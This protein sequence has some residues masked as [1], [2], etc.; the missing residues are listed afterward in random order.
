M[1]DAAYIAPMPTRS[2][3][4]PSRPF[5]VAAASAI[6]SL[7]LAGCGEA[8]GPAP[9]PGLVGRIAFTRVNGAGRDIWV[10]NADGSAQ[11]QLTRGGGEDDPAF[12]PDGTQ[13]A[14]SHNADDILVM[15]ANGGSQRNVTAGT[16][17]G[18]LAPSWSR[19]GSRF[20][21]G[22]LNGPVETI[23][24]S[25]LDRRTVGNGASPDWAL[26]GEHVLLV[27]FADPMSNELPGIVSVSLDGLQRTRVSPPTAADIDPALSPDGAHIA[28]VLRTITNTGGSYRTTYGIGIMRADGTDRRLVV[29]DTVAAYRTPVWSPDGTH[30]AFMSTRSGT[31]DIWVVRT[32]GGRLRQLTRSA[33]GAGQG[34]HR[35]SHPTWTTP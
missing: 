8:S 3:P 26:D 21:F 9:D 24:V 12:S 20:A 17:D 23:T 18:E 7:V 16:T 31:E 2:L 27:G 35:S 10:M 1:P 14:F 5:V 28:Y 34:D 25:G 33:S 19:D 32:D 13:I 11:T 29:G 22:T 15:D 4:A 30:L 6:L